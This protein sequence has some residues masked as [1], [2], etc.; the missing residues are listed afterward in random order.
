MEY[1]GLVVGII[2]HPLLNVLPQY[3]ISSGERLDK[4]SVMICIIQGKWIH[5]SIDSTTATT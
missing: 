5:Q 3:I 4:H 2:L 1:H